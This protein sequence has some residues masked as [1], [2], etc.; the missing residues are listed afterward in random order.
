[1]HTFTYIFTYTYM[2]VCV[3]GWMTVQNENKDYPSLL[4]LYFLCTNLLRSCCCHDNTALS[5]GAWFTFTVLFHSLTA[6]EYNILWKHTDKYMSELI[7]TMVWSVETSSSLLCNSCCFSF[8]R[9]DRDG[10]SIIWRCFNSSTLSLMLCSHSSPFHTSLSP[11]AFC[12]LL[13]LSPTPNLM[14]KNDDL[15]TQTKPYVEESV[16]SKPLVGKVCHWDKD[17]SDVTVFSWHRF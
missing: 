2:H 16:D 8:L 9:C 12:N 5:H 14:E 10:R 7:S 13:S 15:N 3:C 6:L 4:L 11:S 17:F 1:M